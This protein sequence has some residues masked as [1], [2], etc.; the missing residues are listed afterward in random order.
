[1]KV[2]NFWNCFEPACKHTDRA[3]SV[4]S[5]LEASRPCGVGTRGGGPLW[6]CPTIRGEWAATHPYPARKTTAQALEFPQGGRGEV[7]T[8]RCADSG[9]V[10]EC[11]GSP[12]RGIQAPS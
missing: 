9:V 7:R 11:S 1:M 5:A 3:F 4:S 12:G 8:R 6:V 10:L 2:R